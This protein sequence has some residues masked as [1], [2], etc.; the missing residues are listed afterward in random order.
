MSLLNFNPPA[1]CG[2]GQE[3]K[4]QTKI[5]GDF[6]PPA[7]C[8]AGPPCAYRIREYSRFQSTRPVRGGTTG[9]NDWSDL[10]LFQST[11]P[12]RG[13]TLSGVFALWLLRF[14]STRPVRGGTHGRSH[15]T[16]RD[17]FQSTRPVRGG[18][19]DNG[20]CN[21][22][23]SISI[24]PPRAGRDGQDRV[25]S[26][27]A[28]YFNPPAPCG[29]GRDGT[30]PSGQI[31]LISIH[32][33]RAGRDLPGLRMAYL[34]PISIHPPRAGRDV[35][36]YFFN[37]PL[38]YFNPPAPCGAG[39]RGSARG[40]SA[41]DFNP[42]APCG[43]GPVCA[44]LLWRTSSISIHPPR[45]GRDDEDDDIY[46]DIFIS[47]HPPRAGRDPY[48]SAAAI[49]ERLFQSTRP[50]RGGTIVLVV[51]LLIKKF[52]STRPVR[53]GTCSASDPR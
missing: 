17:R 25:K 14:Q 28:R 7:P 21:S 48:D 39:P 35:A 16:R 33:P 47:I 4:A 51:G 37:R 19:I 36:L 3:K 12:V 42:P 2:A 50:V 31:G 9:Y 30:R 45:A 23:S 5:R 1:P 40:H 32:P 11:R 6:N 20:N 13:G 53:G 46:S 41:G 26:S 24:H 10:R 18:T 44:S 29:A 8:G 15:P 43:A 34:Q 52:Q 38:S 49:V 27:K 22:H